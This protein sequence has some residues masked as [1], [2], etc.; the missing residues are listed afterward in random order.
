MKKFFLTKS[1]RKFIQWRPVTF[2]ITILFV[3]A[4][5]LFTGLLFGKVACLFAVIPILG[6]AF[7]D[8]YK[9][10]GKEVFSHNHYMLYGRSYKI[11]RNKK[12][13]AQ[14]VRRQYIRDYSK[15]WK[16]DTVEQVNWN[17]F[18]ATHPIE[19]K[20]RIIYLTGQATFVQFNVI[21]QMATSGVSLLTTP[22]VVD[23]L[24]PILTGLTVV[25]ETLVDSFTIS[26]IKIGDYP[27]GMM[28]E[29]MCTPQ[30]SKGTFT[31]KK[32]KLVGIFDPTVTPAIDITSAYEA[33]FG[34]LQLGMK[35]FVKARLIMPTGES[36]L[37]V[38]QNSI[39]IIHPA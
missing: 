4:C 39:V 1:A 25:T 29:I 35:I 2:V 10:W 15:A 26:P 19:K 6:P 7:N 18:G 32:F 34:V 31:P 11:P 17:N 5:S 3:V 27:S 22:P 20:G 16:D 28:L 23:T 36:D 30:L 13:N 38:S 9:K 33:L 21:A 37:W 8:L 24:F 14:A 12:T